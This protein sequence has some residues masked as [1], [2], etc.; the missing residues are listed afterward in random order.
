MEACQRRFEELESSLKSFIDSNSE[1][2]IKTE[3]K[4]ETICNRLE[5]FESSSSENRGEYTEMEFTTDPVEKNVFN[6][7][8]RVKNS[9]K[10]LSVK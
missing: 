5:R 1:R 2:M 8:Q 3:R 4:L 10:L 6:Q 7:Q 9:F